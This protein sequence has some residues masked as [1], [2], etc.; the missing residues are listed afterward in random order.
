MDRLRDEAI[1]GTERM[2]N[3]REEVAPPQGSSRLGRRIEREK[4]VRL[5]TIGV[6]EDDTV[7]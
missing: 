5:A 2:E 7:I 1:S 3:T 4:R 6:P